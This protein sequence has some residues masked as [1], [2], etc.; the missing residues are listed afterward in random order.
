MDKNRVVVC[1]QCNRLFNSISGKDICPQCSVILE[2]DFQRVKK[3]IRRHDQAGVM[4]VSEA[5]DV[6][7]KYILRWIREERL[8]FAEDSEFGVPCMHCGV[9]INT[10]KY[11][12]PCKKKMVNNLSSAYAINVKD[13]EEDFMTQ[14]NKM[15]SRRFLEEKL[16]KIS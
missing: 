4:E 12:V 15:H 7:T 2:R 9:T 8:F 13:E 11:C 6:P 16:H 5:C 14:K 10:G 1:K 3:Y